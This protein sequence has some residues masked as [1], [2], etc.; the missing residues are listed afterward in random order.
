MKTDASQSKA[1]RKS[2]LF[3]YGG[4]SEIKRKKPPLFLNKLKSTNL[5]KIPSRGFFS[6]RKKSMVSPETTQ[7]SEK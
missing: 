3:E 4:H 5:A 2:L 7:T 6:F 1:S